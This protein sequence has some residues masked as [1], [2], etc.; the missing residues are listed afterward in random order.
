MSAA[1]LVR[2]GNAVEHAGLRAV[3]FLVFFAVFV[4]E[5]HHQLQVGAMKAREGLDRPIAAAKNALPPGD[6]AE[7][8]SNPSAASRVHQRPSTIAAAPHLTHSIM[9]KY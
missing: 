9:S 3:E 4:G 5:L 8:K 1:L 2:I 7:N 6:R